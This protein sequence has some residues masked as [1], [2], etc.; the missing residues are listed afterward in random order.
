MPHLGHLG[1]IVTGKLFSSLQTGFS[2]QLGLSPAI[3]RPSTIDLKTLQLTY[4]EE[5]RPRPSTLAY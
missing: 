5:T 3:S 2:L 1:V 4:P